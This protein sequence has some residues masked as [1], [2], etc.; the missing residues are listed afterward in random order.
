MVKDDRKS[1]R[2]EGSFFGREKRGFFDRM[3]R[4]DGMMKAGPIAGLATE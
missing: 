4:I 2:R 3:N 1:R